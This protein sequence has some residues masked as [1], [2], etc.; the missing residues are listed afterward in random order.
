MITIDII[1]EDADGEEVI[2]TTHF[3]LTKLDLMKLDQELGG[4]ESYLERIKQSSHPEEILSVV[5]DIVRRSYGVRKGDRFLKN[6]EETEF[7]ISSDAYSELFIE[8]LSDP[9][10]MI[11]FITGILPKTVVDQADVKKA[12]ENLSENN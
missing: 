5:E 11:D 12:F 6:P 3:H 7:F 8:L 4:F 10:K 9:T 2:T 1:H